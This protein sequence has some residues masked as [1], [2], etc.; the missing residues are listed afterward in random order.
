MPEPVDP[1]AAVA[2]D[3]ENNRIDVDVIYPVKQRLD[4]VL[5][6]INAEHGDDILLLPMSGQS[7]GSGIFQA[8][9]PVE[10]ATGHPV[11][12][13]RFDPPVSP[14]IARGSCE[15]LTRIEADQVVIDHS[16]QQVCAGA[17]ITLD[18]LNRALEQE[19]GGGFKVLG[20]DLTSYTYAAVG[21]TFMTG[22]MGPQR[23]YF[24]DSVRQ[25]AL[26]DGQAI[27]LVE[28]DQLAGYAAT[29]GWS[30]IVSAVRCD[31]HR[32]PPN[33]IAFA[34]P[35]SQSADHFARLAE[36]LAPY[37]FVQLESGRVV[38]RNGGSDLV[39]GIEHVTRDS[40][41]PMLREGT[42]SPVIRRTQDL[43]NQCLQA[44]ADGLVFI[45][46]YSDAEIDEF[47]FALVDDPDAEALTL[48][49]IDLEHAEVFNDA[50]LMRA[51]REAIPA[52]AR[53]QTPAGKH[54]YKYHTDATVRLNPD[55]VG[56][57]MQSLWQATE[58]YLERL[59]VL[60]DAADGVRGEVLVYGHMNPYGVDP[61]NR[62]TL[63]GDDP[64]Q[65]A[66]AKKALQA[67]R[68]AYY[69]DLLEVCHKTGSEFIG[70]EKGADSERVQV[71]LFAQHGLLPRQL[72][73]KFKRQ[74][75]TIQ[76]ASSRFNWRSLPPYK[77]N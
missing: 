23:R 41:Q 36:R 12:G 42:D 57:S 31:Y 11:I 19:L 7:A 1:T 24:S 68:N 67:A 40:M 5:A 21:A 48:G 69:L 50:D 15:Q 45:S 43:H 77:P 35:L 6:R 37:C 65:F 39:L 8:P 61:H 64:E 4:Q 56:P 22:G 30:G 74:Q 63:A 44:N 55:A 18:Q 59:R 75:V 72:R 76:A 10:L 27:R 33:E 66:Q 13:L 25:I 54:L 34:L 70:G 32:L 51:V 73:D 2:T 47:L 20:A 28:G 46:G 62:I 3:G 52:A 29:Y 9:R 26:Y 49:G 38:N 53:T 16:L 71:A 60:L 14:R 17:A 58:R